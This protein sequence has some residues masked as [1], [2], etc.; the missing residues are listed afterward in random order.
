MAKFS[1]NDIVRI[2]RAA[3]SGFPY[4]RAWIVGIFDERLGPYFDKFPS[5]TVYTIEFEDGSSIEVHEGS[6]ELDASN[7]EERPPA[8]PAS[9]GEPPGI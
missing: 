4:G 3:E 1:Y 5:G 6:L 2:K 8:V 9:E 7:A